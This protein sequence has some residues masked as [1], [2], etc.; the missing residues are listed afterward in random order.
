VKAIAAPAFRD[1]CHIGGVVL[2]EKG[3]AP[4]KGFPTIE[5]VESAGKEQLATLVSLL[6]LRRDCSTPG[7]HEAE[8]PHATASNS[9]FSAKQSLVFSSRLFSG[10]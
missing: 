5:E 9:T 1:F 3:S 2:S 7:D 8:A 4:A 10:A 6:A